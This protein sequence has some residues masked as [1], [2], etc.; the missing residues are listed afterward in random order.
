MV[1]AGGRVLPDTSASKPIS[2]TRQRLL[3]WPTSNCQS[4]RCWMLSFV[5]MEHQAPIRFEKAQKSSQLF[6]AFLS[7]QDQSIRLMPVPESHH[8]KTCSEEQKQVMRL[9]YLS[10]VSK[11]RRW[12]VSFA[13]YP[14]QSCPRPRFVC[15]NCL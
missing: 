6:S 7:A 10:I 13:Q 4:V 2:W 3:L 9:I 1:S 14:L 11:C 5:G 15:G 12:K 8:L